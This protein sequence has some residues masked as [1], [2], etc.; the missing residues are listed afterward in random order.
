MA[1]RRGSSGLDDS[2]RRLWTIDRTPS[3][4]V[5]HKGRSEGFMLLFHRM[6]FE[7]FLFLCCICILISVIKLLAKN[8]DKH[9]YSSFS[10]DDSFAGYR[11]SESSSKYLARG[12]LQT[13]ILVTKSFAAFS[14]M[15]SVN[16]WAKK[17]NF[18]IK[19]T[20]QS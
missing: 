9:T 15:S 18:T 6:N 10:S 16:L 7:C 12:F 19:S 1:D 4:E 20:L 5:I 11:K 3:S 13:R 8:K 17:F 2:H 14:A